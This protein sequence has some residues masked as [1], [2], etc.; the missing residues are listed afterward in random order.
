PRR[1]VRSSHPC[2]IIGPCVVIGP[3]GVRRRPCPVIPGRP[4]NVRRRPCPVIPGRPF[5]VRRRPCPVSF[6]CPLRPV[7]PAR[8]LRSR[9]PWRRDVFALGPGDRL[10]RGSGLVK[11]GDQVAPC[12]VLVA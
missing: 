11:P 4:F 1:P 10:V 9:G 6:T 3:S 5:N 12:R 2:V 8:P 7:S